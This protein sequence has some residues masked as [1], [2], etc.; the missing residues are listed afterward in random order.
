MS[1]P[2]VYEK[3]V[4][5]IQEGEQTLLPYFEACIQE[6]LRLHS[7]VNWLLPREVGPEGLEIGGYFLPPGTTVGASPWVS[8]QE[9]VVFGEDANVF[10]PERWMEA[11][12]EQAY[13]M[14][15]CLLAWGSGSR[16]CPG[17]HI[18]SG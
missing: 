11:S 3:I 1:N 14:D 5:E 2:K 7:P 8:Q 4:A 18:V 13:L 15:K 6:A 10:R 9:S 16:I 12:K 17:R